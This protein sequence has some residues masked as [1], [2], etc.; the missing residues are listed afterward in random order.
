MLVSL[1]E[2]AFGSATAAHDALAGALV[3][4]GRSDL[5]PTAPELVA[6]VRAHLLPTLSDQ[7]G[8]RLTM[9]LIDDLVEKLEPGRASSTEDSAPP[10]SMPRPIARI[11]P[12]PPSNSDIR[13]AKLGVVLV[14]ADRVGRTAVARAFLRA[15][16][17]V[18][19]VESAADL[20]S[21]L[22]SGDPLDAA[23]VDAAHPATQAILDE[24][25]SN[26][27]DA[28]VVV[29]SSDAIRTRAHLGDIG[30]KRFDV[31][32]REAPAEELI[33]TIKRARGA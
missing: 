3:L 6:F 24:L 16:W 30:V 8:A 19:V 33:D 27:P 21:L 31:R 32:A 26:R 9:A 13:R 23:V 1:L 28:V 2:M 7:I 11:G 5:P 18:T 15:H 29:R 20:A 17:D 25:L 22:D 12:A 14:D 10:S 4:A